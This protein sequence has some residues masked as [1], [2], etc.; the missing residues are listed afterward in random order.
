M[1]VFFKEI[2]VL[3]YDSFI[4][5]IITNMRKIFDDVQ[6]KRIVSTTNSFMCGIP[7]ERK[8]S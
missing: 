6:R 1:Y 5:K 3:F 4:M 7:S 2:F 8:R